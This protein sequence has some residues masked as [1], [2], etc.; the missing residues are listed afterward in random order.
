MKK[1]KVSGKFAE[2]QI[3]AQAAMFIKNLLL[4]T[5]RMAKVGPIENDRFLPVYCPEDSQ[6]TVKSTL[7]TLGAEEVLVEPA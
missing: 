2:G 6:E 7:E 4:K 3:A 1:V 5:D